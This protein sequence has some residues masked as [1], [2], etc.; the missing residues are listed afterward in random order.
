VAQ[1]TQP[2]DLHALA[3]PASRLGEAIELLVRKGRLLPH[4][5]EVAAPPEN[6]E[7]ADDEALGRWI[8]VAAG[9]LGLEAEPVESSYAEVDQLVRG[10]SPALLRLPGTFDEGEPRFLALLRGG[11][12]RISVVG[13]DLS[14]RRVRPEAIRGAL[15]YELEAPLVG[16][17]DQLL[18]E[19]GVPE[20]RRGRARMAILREW[21]SPAR[22]GGC[23]LLR[24]APGA[25]FW[26]QVRY[27]RLFRPLLTLVGAH[28]VGQILRIFAWWVI[29]R[30]ALQGHFDWA[31]LLVWA[32]ILFTT[33]PFQLVMTW[34]QSLFAIGAG[35]LFK[36]RLLYGTLQ[37]EPEEIRH[38]GAGQFLGRVME[39]EAVELLALSGGLMAV[40]AVIELGMAAAVLAMGAGGW[41]HA[42]SL[43]GW[44]AFTILIGWRYLRRGH[45][46]IEAYREITND[47]VERMVGHRTRLAQE[48][49]EHWHDEEDQILARYLKLS[50]R[51]DQI[52][53]QLDA[54]IHRGWLVLGLSG[55]VYTFTVAPDS[56]AELAISLGGIIL[57]FQA[58]SSLVMG[59]RSVVEAMMAWK[60]VA[61]L[62]QA[63]A[64]PRDAQALALVLPS[65]LDKDALEDGQLVLVARDLVFRYRDRGQPVL[66]ECSLQ[67]R[68]GDRLLL[69]GPSGGGKSTLAALLAG[70][71]APETGLLLL[72]GFD[73]QTVGV[74][75]WR[76]RVVAAPQF[77]ENHVFT[78][79]F[80]FNLLMGRRWPPRPGDFEEA[81]AVCRELGLGD[82]L[83]RMPAGFQQMVGESGWQLS[84]GERSRLYIARALLQEADLII[85]DES[86][87]AL[88]PENLHRALCCVLNR[89]TTLLA[90]AHP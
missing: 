28:V 12:W 89:A 24:H 67:V 77:H 29:G 79:T 21:L 71:R 55:I 86:F 11:W 69:E 41:L 57:A 90:I 51:L 13:P 36:Q 8:D 7:Q 62:F 56:P 48:D 18:A 42:L 4:P 88:D 64:R 63:A 9:R 27:A 59:M 20:D 87:A 19:A 34:A 65:R 26:G 52:G 35:G 33:I 61:P 70:L 25:N 10:V 46:W 2:S 49:R 58:L 45:P 54:F 38:Q 75:E 73:R 37:L 40:V 39:S 14:V 84:H 15:C 66:R 44:A 3:W 32:L 53:V 50:E 76:R 82:L 17:V 60:Q 1:L 78:E 22:I 5:G 80:G 43:L 74:D 85:L 30:G 16:P 83:D 68:K 72:W 23:W 6:F 47:L 81:E 31:W